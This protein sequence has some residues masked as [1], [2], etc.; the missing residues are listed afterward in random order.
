VVEQSLAERTA[1]IGA[2]V[3]VPCLDG[4]TRRYVDLDYA[5]STPA[6]AGVWAAVEEFMPWC[7]SVHRGSGYKSQ[8]ATTAYEGARAAVA[9]F[10]GA[11]D[12]TVV[13]VR[14]TTEAINVLATALPVGTRVLS[15]AAEHHANMLPWRRHDL[16]VL[17]VAGSAW[18]LVERCEHALRVAQPRID[19][20]AVTGAS[21]VTGEVWPLA[22]LAAVAHH[23][24]AGLFVDAAQLAPHRAID[25]AATGIDYLALSGHKLYA[26]FG[27]GALVACGPALERGEPLLH[28]G[29][30]IEVV[31]LDYVDWAHAPE[32]YEAGS[33]NVVG[34]VALGA[35][36][37]IL[38]QLGMQ[39][40]EAHERGLS[41][42]LATGLA[43]VPRL[44]RLAL[45]DDPV[46]D[47]VGLATFELDGYRHPLL[48]AILS[49]EHAIGVRHGC[50]CAHPL[51]AHL[52]GVPEDD[53]RALRAEVRSG[54]RPAMPGAVRASFGLGTTAQDVDRLVDALAAI[55]DSG[56]RWS[57]VRDGA[58]DEYRPA[59]DVRALPRT[60]RYEPAA[61]SASAR[62]LRS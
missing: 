44:R 59:P 14:N 48:A 28:G 12:G 21:N 52:L 51:L 38:G 56:P 29:G 25:M 57:Y 9:E 46:V 40:V 30:A 18:E 31:T 37:R 26:P 20:V 39:R 17:P 34:A 33:P 15:T 7:S 36:C 47:R 8:L 43:R 49:A 27:A 5:A 58:H 54:R 61:A 60:P 50:F 10:V 53:L 1:M 41:A 4:Q 13:L 45:W 19:L 11:R 22:E 24:G 35:A 23:Y 2:D 32:R 3:Q 16:T 62:P 42:R 55:A 6:M